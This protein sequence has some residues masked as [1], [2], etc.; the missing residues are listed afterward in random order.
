[1]S[2][3]TTAPT[4]LGDLVWYRIVASRYPC[5]E[6]H[7]GLSGLRRASG[8]A[9]PSSHG[10]F[11][12]PRRTARQVLVGVPGSWVCCVHPA[13]INGTR[14]LVCLACREEVN[15]SLDAGVVFTDHAP[16]LCGTLRYNYCPC[17]CARTYDWQ[18]TVAILSQGYVWDIAQHLSERALGRPDCSVSP[19]RRSACTPAGEV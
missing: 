1:M 14:F 13:V 12:G 10:S 5:V 8:A 18:R 15:H 17:I 9:R 11:W 2:S 19:A 7:Q 16:R 3:T 4:A 6:G